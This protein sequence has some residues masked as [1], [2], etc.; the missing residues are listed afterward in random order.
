MIELCQF[1]CL[2]DG[3]QTV[4][5][6]NMVI[7]DGEM[8]SLVGPSGCGKTTLLK[9]ICGLH[10]EVTGSVRVNGQDV[11]YQSPHKRASIL[12]FQEHLLY[13]HLNVVENIAFGLKMRGIS[14][15]RRYE[16][17]KPFIAKMGLDGLE[18][19]YPNALSGG[20]RQ[21]VALARAL[22]VEPQVLLLDEPFS[23]LDEQLRN[24]MREFVCSLQKE[25]GITTIF[26]T[27]DIEEALM[28]SQRVAVMMDGELRQFSTPKKLYQQPE[29]LQVAK[30]LS[31][32]SYI[33]GRVEA[34]YFLWHETKI[35]YEGPQK[36]NDG[37]AVA[38]LTPEAIKVVGPDKGQV[39]CRVEAINFG[40]AKYHVSL[41]IEKKTYQVI[42]LAP[43]EIEVGDFVGLV[44]DGKRLSVFE[45]E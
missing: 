3:K 17:V 15:R 2:Y 9:G 37:P 22:A 5:N 19:R 16:M 25:F 29:N 43:Q 45:Q 44:I 28:S 18:N 10:E 4:K 40:G 31:G 36:L 13:P 33:E 6:I 39:I 8:V 30:L 7:E 11:T 12:V 14:K 26:V 27:H 24:E 38:V 20:Q 1:N 35:A 41:S 32:R 21:R 34:G 23:S 42:L